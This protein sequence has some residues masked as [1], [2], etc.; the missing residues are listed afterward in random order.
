MRVCRLLLVTACVMWSATAL[1]SLADIK[2]WQTGETIPDT[3]E[4]APGPG[5]NLSGWNSDDP[6]GFCEP[7]NRPTVAA[8]RW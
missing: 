6:R 4:I 8:F 3:Q 2:N 5:V 7:T 1:T